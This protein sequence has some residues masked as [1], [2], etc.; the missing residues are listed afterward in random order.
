[1]IMVMIT[2]EKPLITDVG[3]GRFNLEIAPASIVA[4]L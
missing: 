1:M 4:K 3:I 2:T